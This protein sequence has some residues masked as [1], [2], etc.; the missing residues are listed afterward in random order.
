MSRTGAPL[1]CKRA[2]V[3]ASSEYQNARKFVLFLRRKCWEHSEKKASG[4]PINGPDSGRQNFM[5]DGPSVPTWGCRFFLEAEDESGCGGDFYKD[6]WATPYF[7]LRLAI[8][9]QSDVCDP[10]RAGGQTSMSRCAEFAMLRFATADVPTSLL[11]ALGA[12]QHKRDVCVCVDTIAQAL[13]AGNHSQQIT[14]CSS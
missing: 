6:G 7:G 3:E 11:R 4:E 9:R 1:R 8:L 10:H 14:S 12:G 5:P 2:L 13:P